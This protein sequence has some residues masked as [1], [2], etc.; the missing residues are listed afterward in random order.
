MFNKQFKEKCGKGWWSTSVS[1]ILRGYLWQRS[2]YLRRRAFGI[3]QNEKGAQQ[4]LLKPSNLLWKH[5]DGDFKIFSSRDKDPILEVL[6]GQIDDFDDITNVLCE[7]C[8]LTD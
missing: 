2:E 8:L 5:P 7:E 3:N 4:R 6:E 1:F